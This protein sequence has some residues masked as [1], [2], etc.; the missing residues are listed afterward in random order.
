M[1]V[2]RAG[3]W[4]GDSKPAKDA[5]DDREVDFPPAEPLGSPFQTSDGLTASEGAVAL[6]VD[7]FE[8]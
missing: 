8:G 5:Q 4:F 6:P 3:I 7:D 1:F 2:S